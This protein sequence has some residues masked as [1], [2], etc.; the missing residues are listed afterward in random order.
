M[1]VDVLTLAALAFFGGRLAMNAGRAARSTDARQRT[2]VIARGLRLR[3]LLLA[4]LVMMGVLIT[5]GVLYQVKPLQFGW[6][7]AL[8]GTGNI[9][10]GSTTRTH[11]TALEWI[12]PA[13]FLS[14]VFPL[15]P[16]FA[17]REEEMFRL[18]AENWSTGRRIRRGLEFGLVHLIM[19][20]PIAV[21]L[22]LSVGGW[23]FTWAYLRGYRRTG[24]QWEA[25]MESTRSHLA[26]N[27]EIITI[28]ILVLI[29]TGGL[30]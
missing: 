14:L 28:A 18:G 17:A 15:L 21:A 4:P 6:W 19:G 7:T 11:G 29:L 22:A 8:G 26:Y 3:H 12:V 13:F 1:L 23:Y 16:L 9:I 2:L 10:T 20:I 27:L 24:S 25:M 5:A 30:T